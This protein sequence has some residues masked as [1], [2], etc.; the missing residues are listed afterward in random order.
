M[1][2][3]SASRILI[4]EMTGAELFPCLTYVQK[5]EKKKNEETVGLNG[6]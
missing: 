2:R 4:S 6:I 5:M 3:E 1:G